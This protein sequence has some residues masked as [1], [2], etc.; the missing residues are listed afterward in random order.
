MLLA[1][2]PG[3][4]A[5]PSRPRIS[6]VRPNVFFSNYD[7]PSCAH[8]RAS[9]EKRSPL[10]STRK[11][12]T[13]ERVL[14]RA[15]RAP[16][17]NNL[18]QRGQILVNIWGAVRNKTKTA[19]LPTCSAGK[20]GRAFQIKSAGVAKTSPQPKNRCR[21]RL[22]EQIHSARGLPTVDCSSLLMV[23]PCLLL[24]VSQRSVTTK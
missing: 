4:N 22:S 18:G 9:E 14:V 6:L 2:S 17:G 7:G 5:V 24:L 12:I 1:R 23:S 13:S 15:Q 8:A 16:P 10:H 20:N 21:R 3:K 11:Q 19:L